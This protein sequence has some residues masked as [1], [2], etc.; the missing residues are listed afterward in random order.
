LTASERARPLGFTAGQ[1]GDER[2][3]VRDHGVGATDEEVACAPDHVSLR[4]QPL[5]DLTLHLFR[6]AEHVV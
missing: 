6:V 1:G 2:G 4:V 3:R 5:R